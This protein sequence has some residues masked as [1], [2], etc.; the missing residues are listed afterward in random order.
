MSLSNISKDYCGF[1]QRLHGELSA[2]K[3]SP[4][5]LATALGV[6]RQ[7]VY[8]WLSRNRISPANLHALCSHLNVD[9]EWL[10][11]GRKSSDYGAS[12][13][14][15]EA[16]NKFI[17]DV[18]AS[19][20][21]LR[22][23]ARTAMLLIWE[24]D[25]VS[26]R[27]TWYG[28]APSLDGF[29]RPTLDVFLQQVD[30]GFRK[31]MQQSLNQLF[32]LGG[33]DQ[34]EIPLRLRGDQRVWV[35]A[36][37]RPVVDDNGRYCGL[38]GV[39]KDVTSQHRTEE[40]LRQAR[41]ELEERVKRRTG[42]LTAANRS[43]KEEMARREQVERQAQAERS[44]LDRY[45]MTLPALVVVLDRRG[46]MTLLND[47]SRELL[48]YS[49]S[50]PVARKCF[51]RY[52]PEDVNGRM[53]RLFERVLAGEE[54]DARCVD[55][56]LITRDGLHRL[57][58]WRCTPLTDADGRVEGAI[59]IGEDV[60]AQREAER[61]SQ[62]AAAI[63]EH[64]PEAIVVTDPQ[65]VIRTSNPAFSSLTRYTAE[66][67]AGMCILELCSDPGLD[68]RIRATLTDDGHWSGQVWIR[69]KQES[70]LLLW[71]TFLAVAGRNGVPRDCIATFIDI[72][73]AQ[74]KSLGTLAPLYYDAL[75]GLPTSELFH[76]RFNLAIVQSQRL[77]RKVGLLYIEMTDA[78]EIGQEIVGRH[79]HV[80]KALAERICLSVRRG[81]TVARIGTS[82]F[83]LILPDPDATR[84]IGV[85]MK[86][87]TAAAT[88][89]FKVGDFVPRILIRSSVATY[90]DDG[91][92]PD[93]LMA[94]ARS[95]LDR[96][97]NSGVTSH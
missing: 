51:A 87:V 36:S 16:R 63:V 70:Q 24:Y 50:M 30:P 43:L 82:R 2:R 40:S 58:D 94:C 3:L 21:R 78:P 14:L 35:N 19:E 53:R 75:T 66:E 10:L 77:G 32:A 93:S 9:P 29:K 84:D 23:A 62:L 20:R 91:R 80:I 13:L 52:L 90:P 88:A 8:N 26:R 31:L 5:E 7:T 79:D 95:R 64:T 97:A 81:D 34:R 17:N 59:F 76:D 57:V 25:L 56:P 72:S 60:T 18:L 27:V 47:R 12:Q 86:K 39:L 4:A 33:T 22:L 55:V 49:E 48:G 68:G 44:R 65:L 69:G 61:R 1:S 28:E 15:T 73:N 74:G 41:A 46:R 71:A 11:Y 92:D 37:T 96:E 45:L 85:V 6:S 38:I 67:L 54:P 83:G 89:P 42:E